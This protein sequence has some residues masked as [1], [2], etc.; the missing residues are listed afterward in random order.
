MGQFEVS[1]RMKVRAGLREEFERQAAEVL[2][3]TSEKDT[4]TLRYDWF[5]SD[6]GVDVEIREAYVDA[7]GFLEH[8]RNIDTALSKLFSDFADDHNV[9][10]YGEVPDELVEFANTRMPPGSVKWYRFLDGLAQVR[11]A[12]G[13]EVGMWLKVRA[14]QLA[15]L[16]EQ[17][18][19]CVEQTR[20]KDT[21]TLRYDWFVSTDGTECETREAYVDSDGAWEHRLENVAEE[22]NEVLRRFADDPVVTVYGPATAEVKDLAN[23]RM[24]DAVRWFTFFQGLDS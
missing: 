3:L 1:A 2:R 8:R 16:E 15:G 11:P 20:E 7:D 14:G 6:N 24:G 12:R 23:V 17:A 21:T 9:A 10:V 5:L 19:R 22:T 18:S 13:L 4:R